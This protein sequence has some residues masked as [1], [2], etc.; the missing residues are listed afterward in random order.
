MKVERLV[1]WST[2]ETTEKT[3]I[4]TIN[5]STPMMFHTH[6]CWSRRMKPTTH[7]RKLKFSALKIN[8]RK[9]SSTFQENFRGSFL[10]HPEIIDDKKNSFY[11]FDKIDLTATFDDY[12]QLNL[13][14]FLP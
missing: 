13:I 14:L 8:L 6:L 7:F 4:S 3:D 10:Y 11:H 9:A 12:F 2:I 1:C 5:R